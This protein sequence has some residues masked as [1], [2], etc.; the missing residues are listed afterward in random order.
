MRLAACPSCARHVRRTEPAC[1]FCGVALALPDAPRV[2]VP[3]RLGRTA[4]FAFGAAALASAGCSAPTEAT[5]APIDTG[6]EVDDG[7]F[8]DVAVYG[9]PDAPSPFDAGT[10]APTAVEDT[11]VDDEDA[12]MDA[13]GVGP[14]YGGPA[15]IDAGIDVGG[16]VT[17]LYGGPPES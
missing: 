14:L 16:G 7:G 4:T 17:P 12:G 11:G 10:D 8:N 13:G 9:G 15:P 3:A 6:T 1:P 5:D 2:V